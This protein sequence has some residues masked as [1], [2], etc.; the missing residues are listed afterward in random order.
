MGLRAFIKEGFEVV[1]AYCNDT[2]QYDK[3]QQQ[4]WFHFLRI[5]RN[6]LS[7]NFKF[8]FSKENKNRFPIT[9]KGKIITKNM[10]GTYLTDAIFGPMEAFVINNEMANFVMNV[11]D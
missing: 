8:D 7:H 10:D 2:E 11:L 5:I 3:F 4:N 6:A 1:K 9:W